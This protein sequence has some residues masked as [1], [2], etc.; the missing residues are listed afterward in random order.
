MWGV[1]AG[2]QMECYLGHGFALMTEA[3]V[4][5]LMDAVHEIAS[6][7]TL[8]KFAGQVENKRGK[9]IWN[10]VPEVEGR[11]SLMWYPWEN[12]QVEFGYEVMAYFNT[13]SSPQPI[14]FNYGNIAPHYA[15]SIRVFDGF[16]A[17][18]GITF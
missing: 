17:G 6:Y 10:V 15:T 8:D 7:E 12:I 11:V 3:R 18:L 9:R 4:S 13:I 16:R 1:D 2:C 5:M 14:D